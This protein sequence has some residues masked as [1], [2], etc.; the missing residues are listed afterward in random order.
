MRNRIFGVVAMLALLGG[1]ESQAET[2]DQAQQEA[3]ARSYFTDLSVMDQDGMEKRFYSDVLKDRVV[4]INFIFTSCE[5]ACPM[6][7]QHLVEV[8]DQLGD[9]LSQ[10]IHF[11]SISVDPARDTPDALRT[12]MQKQRIDGL[13]SWEFITGD[14]SNLDTIIS[15][16]GQYTESVEGHSTL[17]LAGNVNASHWMKIQANLPPQAIAEKLRRLVLG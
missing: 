2:A 11:I 15:K 13:P 4:L 10:Q 5:Q 8:K 12:F 14:K 17:L 9:E 1:V 7:T 16:L 6:I 3:K